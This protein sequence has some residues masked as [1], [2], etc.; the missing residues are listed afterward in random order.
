MFLNRF[1]D[2]KLISF[3]R[4]RKKK[5]LLFRL[6]DSTACA[7]QGIRRVSESTTSRRDRSATVS[8]YRCSTT[9]Y[10][11]CTVRHYIDQPKRL[12]VGLTHAELSNSR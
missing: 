8:L 6:A 4:L 1:A 2:K 3:S 12:A 5:G 11:G 10:D 9:T 7:G